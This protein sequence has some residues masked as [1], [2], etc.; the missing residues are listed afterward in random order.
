MLRKAEKERKTDRAFTPRGPF[1]RNP[2]MAWIEHAFVLFLVLLL[3]L[4]RGELR[5]LP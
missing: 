1:L 3:P 4:Q 5:S 2:L